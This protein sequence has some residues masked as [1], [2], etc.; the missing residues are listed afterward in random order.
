L[1][2]RLTQGRRSEWGRRWNE[3]IFTAIGT[4]RKQGRSAWQFLQEAI[5]AHYFHTPMP[6]LIPQTS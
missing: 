1:N 5:A 6:S 2:Q 4:C 3:R